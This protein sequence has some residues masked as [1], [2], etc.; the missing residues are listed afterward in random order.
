MTVQHLDWV[1]SSGWVVGNG[2][3]GGHRVAIVMEPEASEQK[4]VVWTLRSLV[5]VLY[6]LYLLVL[7][8]VL[9]HS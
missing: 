3:R 6:L 7:T 2:M 1:A 5:M 4:N 8:S 9:T